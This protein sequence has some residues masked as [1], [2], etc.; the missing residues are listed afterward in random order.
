MVV[1][2]FTL[3]PPNNLLG[4]LAFLYDGS[5]RRSPSPTPEPTWNNFS[6]D[7]I[8]ALSPASVN[9]VISAG[10]L[11]MDLSELLQ[12][13]ADR[14]SL[15]N[16]E[17]CSVEQYYTWTGTVWHRFLILELNREERK[18]IWVRLDRHRGGGLKDL[19][20]GTAPAHDEVHFCRC[21]LGRRLDPS[22]SY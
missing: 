10:T 12:T 22:S 6:L 5:G 18:A 19:W 8:N 14:Q 3:M 2:V 11:V 4:Q 20:A 13:I 16:A 9:T 15:R 1:H 7:G 17:I 21:V